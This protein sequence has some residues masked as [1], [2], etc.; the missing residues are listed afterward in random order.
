VPGGETLAYK[1]APTSKRIL[2][3]ER[4]DFLPRWKSAAVWGDSGALGPAAG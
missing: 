1:L 3:L 2:L 4:G